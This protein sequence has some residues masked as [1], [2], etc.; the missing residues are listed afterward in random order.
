M[1]GLLV[2]YNPSTQ[3]YTRELSAVVLAIRYITKRKN[4]KYAGECFENM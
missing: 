3:I 1:Q 4:N 2:L